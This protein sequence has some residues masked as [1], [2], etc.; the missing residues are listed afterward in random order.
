MV[1]Q[2]IADGQRPASRENGIERVADI[3]HMVAL[4]DSKAVVIESAKLH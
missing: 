3:Q 4:D 2:R 1:D